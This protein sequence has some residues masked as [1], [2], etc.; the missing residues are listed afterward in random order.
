MAIIVQGFILGFDDRAC[1]DPQHLKYERFGFN[2]IINGRAPLRVAHNRSPEQTF[3]W[4]DI[5]HNR[6]GYK[7]ECSIPNRSN[8]HALAR[9]IR[10]GTDGISM[11]FRTIAK[12]RNVHVTI[13]ERARLTEISIVPQ[14]CYPSA[15]CWVVGEPH[16]PE[17]A[18]LAVQWDRNERTSVLTAAQ[19]MNTEAN[20]EQATGR[21]LKEVNPVRAALNAHVFAYLSRAPVR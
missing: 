9:M 10:E 18:E 21:R 5:S 1:I 7:F 2:S 13:I 14:G 11:S 15:R 4:A 20:K 6:F 16:S 3:A 8:S 12:S 17:I 19:M